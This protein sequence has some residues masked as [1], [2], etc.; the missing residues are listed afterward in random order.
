[1]SLR[2]GISFCSAIV[3]ILVTCVSFAHA[4]AFTAGNIV[5]Y[6]VGDG[7]AALTNNGNA[8]FIDE[9]TPAGSFVQAVALPTTASGGNHPL[10]AQGATGS[11]SAIEGLMA[12]STNGQYVMMTGYGTTLGGAAALSTTACTGAG[13]VPRVVGR[14]KFDGTVDT[15]TALTDVSC[16]SNVR[17]ATSDDGTNVWVSGNG[18]GASFATLGA[19]TSTQLAAATTNVRQVQ[20]FGGQLYGAINGG[21]VS[22]IGSG[23]PT[24]GGQTV[25]RSRFRA[26]RRAPTASPS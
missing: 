11:G 7:V 10:I 2:R 1:M 17:S 12:T 16:S 19:T 25:P 15:S 23:L 4:G 22:T 13:G 26:R 6:R 8:V 3:T 9:Y 20:I 14:V 21:A 5:V 24:T 18:T